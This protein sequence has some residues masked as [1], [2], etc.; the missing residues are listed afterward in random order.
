MSAHNTSFYSVISQA[1]QSYFGK[2]I[3]QKKRTKNWTTIRAELKQVEKLEKLLSPLSAR[4]I[5][6]NTLQKQV[7]KLQKLGARLT[8]PH[9]SHSD[10]TT[11]I[12]ILIDEQDLFEKRHNHIK[13][14]QY[15][16]A[17]P[18]ISGIQKKKRGKTRKKHPLEN[19]ITK[20]R[21]VNDAVQSN[22]KR[23]IKT[24]LA[25]CN[26]E[27]HKLEKSGNYRDVSKSGKLFMQAV[28]KRGAR[29]VNNASLKVIGACEKKINQESA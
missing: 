10:I 25:E 22:Q 17:N 2:H 3:P 21:A 15:Q 9:I 20:V 19:V 23:K 6:Q 29:A 7:K 13:E 1:I 16:I 5:D 12:D 14:L 26:R 18:S 24:S 4:N 28:Q 8:L 11:L 27:F